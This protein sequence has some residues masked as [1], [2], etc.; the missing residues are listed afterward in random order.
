M[1]EGRIHANAKRQHLNPSN[2]GLELFLRHTPGRNPTVH[3][4][5]IFMKFVVI[6]PPFKSRNSYAEKGGAQERLL[7]KRH[8]I[9][10]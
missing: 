9:K 3:Q 1:D 2:D 4:M 8:K 6:S 7:V 10:N 5:H